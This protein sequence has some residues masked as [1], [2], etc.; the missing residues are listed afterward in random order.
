MTNVEIKQVLINKGIDRLY[1]ANSVRTAITF[2]ENGGLL[3]REAVEERGLFQ[4]R[5]FSDDTDKELNIFNDIFLDSADIHEAASNLNKY[6]PI[7]F[8]YSI[9]LID[10]LPENVIKITKSNPIYWNAAMHED[11]KYFTTLDELNASYMKQQF[12]QHF[13]IIE[14]NDPLPFTHLREIIIDNPHSPE[15][16]EL[17]ENAKQEIEE[18]MAANNIDVRLT[19][20][21]CPD[22][23]GCRTSYAD[24]RRRLFVMYTTERN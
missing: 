15:D 11:E 7:L 18:T 16:E 24:N 10:D 6:G 22:G 21:R 1:H 8:V 23:C 19:V 4:T 3:S 20:R 13:T 2:L 14:Q 5:Q 9:D 12:G 17:F